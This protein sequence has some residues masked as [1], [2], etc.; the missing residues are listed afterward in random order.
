MKLLFFMVICAG[1]VQAQLAPFID[2]SG[3]FRT[4]YKTNF[5]Q[6]EFQPIVS[7]EAGDQMIAYVDMRGDFKVYDGEKSELIT[8]QIVQYKLSDAQL[9]W[10]IGPTLF[11]LS[12]GKKR[13]LT[14]F[15]GRY[16]VSDSLIVFEDTRFNTV[17]VFY[18]DEII[19][20][21]QMTGDL[22]MPQFIGDNI[23]AFKDFGDMYR[24][25]WQGRTYEL[26]IWTMNEINF[27]AGRDLVCFNDPTHQSF[28][29]FEAHEFHDLEPFFVSKYKAGWGFCVYEDLNGNLKHYKNGVVTELSNFGA[30]YWE[31]KDDVVIWAENSFYYTFYEGEKIQLTNYKP[32]DLE[33]KNGIIAFRNIMGGVSAFMNGRVHEITNQPE[34]SYKIY[35]DLVLVELFNKT[36]VV[37]RNGKKYEA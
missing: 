30:S 19:Q 37:Y 13:M 9:A 1:F 12:K 3:Y 22:M 34:A 6:I 16:E 21:S 28:A 33:I 35:G 20:L 4:F 29:V 15:A 5:R 14:T 8:N 26:G 24:I 7:Y 17:N 27:K 36:F 23:I 11:A 2:F 18:N 25:F 10:N 31:V 32:A